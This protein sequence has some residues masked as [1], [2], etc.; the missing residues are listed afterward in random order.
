MEG[1]IPRFIFS[2]E[3]SDQLYKRFN[4]GFSSGLFS[5]QNRANSGTD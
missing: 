5:R 3:F 2:L 4:F 1:K